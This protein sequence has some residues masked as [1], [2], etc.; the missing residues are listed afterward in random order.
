MAGLFEAAHLTFLLLRWL[1]REFGPIVEALM[2]SMID[3]WH[4]LQLRHGITF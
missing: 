1:V 4:D 2:L 3:S